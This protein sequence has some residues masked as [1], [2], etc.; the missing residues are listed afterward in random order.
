MTITETFRLDIPLNASL[1]D[2]IQLV[3]ANYEVAIEYRGTTIVISGIQAA[4]IRALK[5]ISSVVLERVR[6]NRAI[7]IPT[8]WEPQESDCELMRIAIGTPKWK[9][10][11]RLM[12]STIATCS[13]LR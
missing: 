12:T 13:I 11:E 8:D 7:S 6:F 3:R 2:Q 5:D 4:V 9:E 10:I 1:Q